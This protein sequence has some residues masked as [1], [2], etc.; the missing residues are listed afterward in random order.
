MKSIIREA[1]GREGKTYKDIA[2]ALGITERSVCNKING[3]RQFSLSEA[4]ALVSYLHIDPNIFF[5]Q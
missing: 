5:A 2:G 3:H 1:M 4:V